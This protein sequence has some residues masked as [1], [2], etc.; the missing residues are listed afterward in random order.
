M[1]PETRNLLEENLRLTK[2]NNRLL[3]KL[4]RAQNIGAFFKIIWIGILVGIPVAAYVYVIQP[5]YEGVQ[6]RFDDFQS[7]VENIPGFGGFFDGNDSN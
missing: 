4:K 5:Y 3:H 6:N 7:R 1:G 2:E